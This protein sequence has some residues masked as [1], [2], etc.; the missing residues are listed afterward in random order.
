MMN[1]KIPQETLNVITYPWN[2]LRSF[3]TFHVTGYPVLWFLNS[4][5]S[6]VSDRLI[7]HEQYLQ[8]ITGELRFS[9]KSDTTPG[10]WTWIFHYVSAYE[11]QVYKVFHR[12]LHLYAVLWHR[13]Q[14][15]SCNIIIKIYADL[16]ARSGNQGQG[17]VITSHWLMQWDIITCPCP[18]DLLLAYKSSYRWLSARLQ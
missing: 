15:V 1:D 12:L 6:H 11:Q 2:N 14:L 10:M 4:A 18:D 13:H 7:L 16:C 9:V 3:G 8:I 5:N 17:Q